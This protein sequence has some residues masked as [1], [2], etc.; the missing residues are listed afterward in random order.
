MSREEDLE[1]SKGYVGTY[2]P[3][4]PLRV[5]FKGFRIIEP[6][7]LDNEPEETPCPARP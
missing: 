5:G 3:S 6:P 2:D 4:K 1:K 7:A